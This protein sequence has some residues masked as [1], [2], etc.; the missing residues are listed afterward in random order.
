MIVRL[1]GVLFALTLLVFTAPSARANSGLSG[2]W[3]GTYSCDG[4]VAE[5]TL[6]GAGTEGI[7]EFVY[8]DGTKGSF[9]V[10]I[11]TDAKGRVNVRPVEWLDQPANFR[12]IGLS[13]RFSDDGTVIS[14]RATGGCKEFS[15]SNPNAVASGS[16]TLAEAAIK[17]DEAKPSESDTSSDGARPENS[18][19]IPSSWESDLGCHHLKSIRLTFQEPDADGYDVQ[20]RVM[21][22]KAVDYTVLR[23]KSSPGRHN[24]GLSIE[25]EPAAGGPLRRNPLLLTT[26]P[27]IWPPNQ[28][29]VNIRNPNCG[30]A[31]LRPAE[32]GGKGQDTELPSGLLALV[33]DWDGAA[34][35]KRSD[36]AIPVSLSV[37][38]STSDVKDRYLEAT[39]VLD[40]IVQPSAILG[41][42]EQVELVP[43]ERSSTTYDAGIYTRLRD[44]GGGGELIT[45]VL[46]DREPLRLFL[47]RRPEGVTASLQERCDKLLT[48]WLEQGKASVVAARKLRVEFY[49][50]LEGYDIDR[51]TAREAIVSAQS[52]DV[53][54]DLQSFVMHC[55]LTADDVRRLPGGGVLDGIIDVEEMLKRRIAM[56]D[57]GTDEAAKLSFGNVVVASPIA[58]TQAAES[59]LK[60]A[61]GQLTAASDVA[62]LLTAVDALTPKIAASRP[63]VAA[64]LLQ[65]VIRE[66][67]M[68]DGAAGETAVAD[69]QNRA[70]ARMAGLVPPPLDAARGALIAA[71]SEGRKTT[72]SPD[73]I[74]FLGGMVAQSL[75]SCG[76]P[77]GATLL[78]VSGLLLQGG[79]LTMGTE[80]SN[81]DLIEMWDSQASGTR[82]YMDGN[83]VVKQLNCGDPWLAGFFDV[84]AMA[85]EERH[86][87]KGGR[88]PLFVRSCALAHGGGS[89]SCLMGALEPLRPGVGKSEFDR[90]MIENAV[91]ANP[92][93]MGPAL[94]R[95]GIG[96]Y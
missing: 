83:T 55:A 57:Y 19:P 16:D 80:F 86:A 89:C 1:S 71:V 96:P 9:K 38:P 17:D 85:T 58:E 72:F 62:G 94:V 60:V 44:G 35:Y 36:K 95:C 51:A 77:S 61:I 75:E 93:T 90:S 7:F 26:S 28:L 29:A 54:S 50:A 48:P 64:E 20:V 81:P 68:L 53:G 15:I 65:P 22:P 70:S 76:S 45:G 2:D 18:P 37:R 84:L 3:K 43:L 66:L 73:E 82:S 59:E 12:M 32:D 92:L 67:E 46:L 79:M 63:T 88:A 78:S 40:G 41:D 74:G 49:P 42:G 25:A 31:R 8:P 52:L 34:Y 4:K 11:R 33:G 24:F 47:W 23:A 30:E 6:K 21:E 14:G 39:M 56:A 5:L 69:R 91:N 87:A 13:G 27:M 10:G